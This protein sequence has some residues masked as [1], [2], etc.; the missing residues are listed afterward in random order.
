MGAL[1]VLELGTQPLLRGIDQHAGALAEQQ[2]FHLDEAEDGARGDGAGVDLVDLALVLEHDL[3]DTL[4]GRVSGT[5]R[6]HGGQP[7]AQAP[8]PR[9]SP[10][11]PHP[12]VTGASVVPSSRERARAV[13][14]STRVSP[15]APQDGQDGTSSRRT[16][17]SKSD[18]H[19]RQVYSY[20]GTRQICPIVAW[21]STGG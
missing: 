13:T 19:V 3:V 4:A 16:S 11:V 7:A 6:S 15:V 12:A 1:D 20:R 2:A 10:H 8:G 17:C 9:G 18:A 5:F 14:D 21:R